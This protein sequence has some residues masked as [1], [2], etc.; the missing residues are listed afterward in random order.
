[1]PR[2]VGDAVGAPSEQPRCAA[3]ALPAAVAEAACDGGQEADALSELP[4]VLLARVL[5]ALL[6]HAE[7]SDAAPRALL[8]LAACSKHLRDAVASADDVWQARAR[9]ARRRERNKK[10]TRAR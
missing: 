10:K 6:V 2:S 4:L 3:P 5:S 8:R 1:M 7:K 9:A